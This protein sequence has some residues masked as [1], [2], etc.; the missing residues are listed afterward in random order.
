MPVA[1]KESPVLK[2]PVKKQEARQEADQIPV[3]FLVNICFS[4][5]GYIPKEQNRLPF[6][7]LEFE[8]N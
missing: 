4:F 8:L 7:E 6:N 1:K 2:I 5:K 3:L